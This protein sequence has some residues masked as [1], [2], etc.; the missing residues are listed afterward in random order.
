VVKFFVGLSTT[1]IGLM[2]ASEPYST[3]IVKWKTFVGSLVFLSLAAFV[4][5]IVNAGSFYRK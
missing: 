5:G 4:F 2:A 3:G 1:G